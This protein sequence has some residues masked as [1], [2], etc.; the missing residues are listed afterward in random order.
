M[1]PK[2]DAFKAGMIAA[3]QHAHNVLVGTDYTIL[4]WSAEDQ[5]LLDRLYK[6]WCEL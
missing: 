6:E 2:K 5:A 1:S 3:L 4:K